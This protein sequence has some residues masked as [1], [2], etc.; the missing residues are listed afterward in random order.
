[1]KIFSRDFT[2]KE[3]ISLL[4]L[5]ILLLVLSY[6]KFV[7][8]PVRD[9]IIAAESEAANLEVELTAVQAKIATL[10]KMKRELDDLSSES[11]VGIMGSYNNS[12]AEMEMLNDILNAADEYSISFADVTRNGDQVRRNFS[13]QF[14]VSDYPTATRILSELTKGTYRCLLSDVR[15]NSSKGNIMEGAVSVSAAATFYETM[16]GGREDAGLPKNSIEEEKV[17]Q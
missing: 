11:N 7:D 1:M 15:C 16:I 10:E 3:K 2:R 6:Y 13:I 17:E 14:T 9:A 8:Q 4:I 5:S 12:K